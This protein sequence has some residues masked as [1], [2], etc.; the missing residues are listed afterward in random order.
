[1]QPQEPDEP[2]DPPEDEVEEEEEENFKEEDEK[3]EGT[4]EPPMESF[5]LE[6]PDPSEMQRPDDD[7]GSEQEEIFEVGEPFR[8]RTIETEKDRVLRR[9]SGRRSRT[10]TAQKQGRYVK[11]EFNRGRGDL[12]ID[13]TLRAAAPFQKSR[14]VAGGPVIVVREGDIREKVREKRTGN[15]IVFVIDASGSMAARARM[16]AAKGAVMSLLLDA[17]Q[18]RDRI[19][20]V[21]FRRTNGELLLPPTPSIELAGRLLADLPVGGRTPLSGGLIEASEVLRK[22]FLR[23]PE[24]R[25]IV[26]LVTDGK[27]NV[28]QGDRRPLDEALSVAEKMGRDPRVKYIVVDTEEQG[29]V[30]F[31]LAAPISQALG[32][33]LFPIDDLK[34]EDLVRIARS[35]TE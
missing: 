2:P 31:G 15:F 24:A 6:L 22:E 18:K 21:A 33:K 4:P 11:S 10:C 25:P 34:A 20:L 35:E 27:S 14:R 28:A 29:I 26:I 17:Y 32:A 19:A 1:V 7:R 3:D 9:G 8:V 30:R 23:R 12:A 13:A 5:E 16:I